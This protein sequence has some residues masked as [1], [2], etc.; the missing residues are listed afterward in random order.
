[1]INSIKDLQNR[2]SVESNTLKS[3]VLA[4]NHVGF[5]PSINDIVIHD[6]QIANSI[7]LNSIL[8]N[9][10]VDLKYAWDLYYNR[11]LNPGESYFQIVSADEDTSILT[12][13]TKLL[14]M[15]DDDNASFYSRNLVLKSE[16][17][18]CD[19]GIA[20][21]LNLDSIWYGI[22]TSGFVHKNK[23][24]S[25]QQIRLITALNDQNVN[26][27]GFG[28][29][30]FDRPITLWDKDDTK[31]KQYQSFNNML[32]Q[33]C[34][35]YKEDMEL[36][37]ISLNYFWGSRFLGTDERADLTNV[38]STIVKSRYL[39]CLSSGLY[40]IQLNFGDSGTV[41]SCTMYDIGRNIPNIKGNYDY[42]STSF[43]D[44][45]GE[46]TL[47]IVFKDKDNKYYYTYFNEE[48]YD[49]VYGFTPIRQLVSDGIVVNPSDVFNQVVSF[50]ELD[51][52]NIAFTDYGF[53]DVET[54]KTNDLTYSYRGSKT[55]GFIEPLQ[56]KYYRNDK[57]V[58]P[59][60]VLSDT[61]KVVEYDKIW[62]LNGD[63][64]HNTDYDL[65]YLQTIFRK[66]NH[67]FVGGNDQFA[68][69]NSDGYNEPP[70]LLIRI[71]DF[72]RYNRLLFSDPTLVRYLIKW[73]YKQVTH[74]DEGEYYLM[75]KY[76]T[77]SKMLNEILTDVRYDN[78]SYQV[79]MSDN[80]VGS[81]FNSIPN[82]LNE[83]QSDSNKLQKYSS[84]IYDII[85]GGTEFNWLM[86]ETDLKER[87]KIDFHDG[88]YRKE[89]LSALVN[90]TVNELISKYKFLLYFRSYLHDKLMC[91]LDT[92]ESNVI[93]L[94]NKSVVLNNVIDYIKSLV[95]RSLVLG[96]YNKGDCKNKEG[97]EKYPELKTYIY[98]N[99]VTLDKSAI[100]EIYSPTTY[101][102]R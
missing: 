48:L 94:Q 35:E 19:D 69:Y 102:H 99:F 7:T 87:I 24:F 33:W 28:C 8:S 79:Q 5:T 36:V 26:P 42:V 64:Y 60:M 67:E 59:T 58:F 16:K 82:L 78:Q 23:V 100:Q 29:N 20:Q 98:N 62:K 44:M 71:E 22:Q 75:V 32:K 77:Y 61:D 30:P 2:T 12:D 55:Y 11:D 73:M 56:K 15:I 63:K 97:N 95:P 31:I 57:I 43:V 1:M 88:A 93:T 90:D 91:D 25:Y 54:N 84:D 45:D 101:S 92:I 3:F 70:Y 17:L 41:Q 72:D 52:T 34:I 4:K 65:S 37:Q 47:F 13:R 53:W 68:V 27:K 86:S 14:L 21:F 96:G 74:P 38:V 83:K 9:F 66:E 50:K 10:I 85:Y 51:T 46:L 40:G 6:Y 80:L 81:K 39:V 89:Y 18:P 76:H 49:K